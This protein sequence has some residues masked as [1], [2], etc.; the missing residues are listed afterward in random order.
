MWWFVAGLTEFKF[1]DSSTIAAFLR[2]KGEI[3]IFLIQCLFET[4]S[5]KLDFQSTLSCSADPIM[6]SLDYYALGY[7]IANCTT[8]ESSW[9][10]KLNNYE[11]SHLFGTTAAETFTQ[12][13]MTKKYSTG[14]ITHLFTYASVEI[15]NTCM[16]AAATS[17]LSSIIELELTGY[18]QLSSNKKRIH[19]FELVSRM[20]H[21]QKLN[22]LGCDLCNAPSSPYCACRDTD[23]LLRFLRYLPHSKVTLLDIRCIGLEYFLEHSPLA[24]DYCAA[25]QALISPPSNLRELVIEPLDDSC[26]D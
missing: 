26:H 3:N 7:C 16:D 13:L 4:Q 12:G 22:I 2:D 23:G 14:V 11:M 5:V 6:T 10:V 8:P 18:N 1:L 19:L 25:I 24:Q 15:L 20:P 21:L 9:K 17:P